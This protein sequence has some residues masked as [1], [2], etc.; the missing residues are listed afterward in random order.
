MAG[1][2]EAFADLVADSLRVL[3]PDHP[4]T[5][6]ARNN[7]AFWRSRPRRGRLRTTRRE[8]E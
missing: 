6:T 1:A 5:L 4:D 7:L 3:G 8:D 2:V